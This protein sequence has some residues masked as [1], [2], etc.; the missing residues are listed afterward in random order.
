MACFLLLGPV[1]CAA[2]PL[3]QMALSSAPAKIPCTSGPG[4]QTATAGFPMSDISGGINQSF[5]KLTGMAVETQPAGVD[6]ANK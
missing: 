1:G 4:C 3:A 6:T 2:V 5:H